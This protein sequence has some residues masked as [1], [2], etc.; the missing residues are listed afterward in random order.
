MRRA[1]AILALAGLITVGATSPAQAATARGLAVQLQ[2][3]GLGCDP[4]KPR[5]YKFWKGT[6]ARCDVLGE[7]I[8]IET[9]GAG[10]LPKGA[11][12]VCSMGLN[13]VGVTNGK[14]WV[15]WPDTRATAQA[16]QAV[17]GG[18]LVKACKL[19]KS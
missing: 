9:Y 10:R 13:P 8:S 18:R 3:G 15:I 12:M 16:I 4:I 17:V 11:A 5:D 1:L 2:Q 14:N 6:A 7:D 19:A